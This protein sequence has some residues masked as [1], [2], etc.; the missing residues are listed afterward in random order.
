M[1]D[2]NIQ[3]KD[4]SG[5][6]LFPKTK[7]SIVINNSNQ[8]LGTVEAGAQVNKLEN[9]KVNGTALTITNKSV[10]IPI[11]YPD[12][13]VV[14]QATADS[15]YSAT[16]YLTK[17][18][19]QVGSKIN[20]AKDMFV[21]SG[22]VKTVTTK[23]NPEQGYNVGDKYID[24]VL[25]NSNNQ[26]LYILVSDLVDTYTAGTA[27]VITNNQISVDTNVL[28]NTFAKKADVYTKADV[29]GLLDNVNSSI[30]GKA[31]AATTLSGYGITDGLTYEE[32]S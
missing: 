24:L 17:D 11:Q 16:Y 31:S 27:I 2:K 7:A 28:A 6:N 21:S 13:T 23:D 25:A 10:D 20:I 12:Y 1:A 30:S 26:H 5:N 15:G 3:I 22:S 4:T 18:G 8:N 19:T 14:K 32:I 29:N 9:V